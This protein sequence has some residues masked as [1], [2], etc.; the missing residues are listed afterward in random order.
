[1][2]TGLATLALAA[3]SAQGASNLTFD[4]DS[5]P[6][7]VL[8]LYADAVWY[9]DNGNPASGGYLSV[10]D[11]FNSQTGIIVFD[12]FDSGLIV[13]GFNFKVDLRIGNSSNAPEFRPAD[14]FSVNY[15]R[16]SDPVVQKVLNGDIP[17]SADFAAGLP[18]AGTVTGIAVG[19][20]TWSGNQLPDGADIEGIIVRVDNVTVHREPLPTRNGACDDPTS[21]QTGFANAD[22]PYDLSNLCWQ[23]LEIDLNEAGQLT[24][25]WKGTTLLDAFQ[26]TFLPSRGRIVFAGRTGGNNQNH[27][28]DNIVISTIAATTATVSGLTP[29]ITGFSLRIDDAPG[30]VVAADSIAVTLDGAAVSTVNTRVGET[31]TVAYALPAGQRF[32]SGAPHAVQISFRDGAGNEFTES[33][34]FNAP[35]YG[36]VAAAYRATDVNTAQTGFRIRPHQVAAANPNTLAWT[37]QQLAGQQGPN[38][39]D[40]AAYGITPDAQGFIAWQDPLDFRNASG[41]AGRFDYDFG[42][43]SLGIPGYTD[44]GSPLLSEDNSALEILTFVE[45]PTA[46]AYTMNVASDDGFRL[47]TGRD[48][49][50]VFATRLG[51]FD[52][53]RGVDDGTTFHVWI[54]EAGIYPMRLVWQ[55]GGGGAGLEWTSIHSDGSHSLVGDTSDARALKAYRTRTATPPYVSSILPARDATQAHAQPTVQVVLQNAG[56]IAAGSAQLSLNGAPLT[57]DSQTAAGQLTVSAVLPSLLASAS[58]NRLELTYTPTGATAVTEAWSFVVIAYNVLPTDG[59]GAP[60]SGTNPGFGVRTHQLDVPGDAVDPAAR[61]A[62]ELTWAEAVLAGRAGPNVADLTGF[63]GGVFHEATTINYAQPGDDGTPE[64]AG[65]FNPNRL[66]PGIPGNGSAPTDNI[67]SEILTFVELPAPGFYLMGVNSDDGF[68]VSAG[69]TAPA[70]PV[71][72]LAPAGIAGSIA[73]VPSVRGDNQGGGIFAPLP[74]TPIEADVVVGL[75]N[76]AT[77]IPEEGCGTALSNAAEVAGKI[78][79]VDRGTCTFLEKA[80]NAANAGAVGVLVAQNRS[81]YPIVLGGDPNTIAIPVLMISQADGARLRTAGARVRIAADP[82]VVLG[83]VNAGRGATDT[84]FGFQ[85]S[86]AG[87]YPLRLLWM[88]GGGGASVEWFSVAPDGTKILINDTASAQALRAFREATVVDVPTLGIGTADGN[89]V[90]TYS[91]TLQSAESVTG[92]YTA[93]PDAPANGPYT[94]APTG[95][96]RFYR[97]VR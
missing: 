61:M 62:T 70:L 41:G 93:V 46:G 89:V 75:G 73:A 39:V 27:H 88:E 1:M 21:L 28:L 82:A 96:L 26:T 53:G 40:L 63:T 49:R 90:I 8:N 45:F 10:T 80:R 14:G 84:L 15:A 33:R 58:T 37:E 72:A 11:N 55:N 52:G 22:D 18:E 6:S 87:L 91:G 44:D 29:S 4:F 13:K 68:R 50:D 35:A 64:T 74:L 31:T 69:H 12:D 94:V 48:A 79:L 67:V 57:T 71:Q 76:S 66:I 51:Q 77:A 92:P 25:K 24:V 36:L 65:N 81:D 7:G 5:D 9:G 43:D 20:D 59:A 95:T 30:S 3:L 2:R 54:E 42:F 83:S 47:Q 86:Q 85:A 97:A 60:G 17:A 34:T 38:L 23:P 16:E 32:D 78:V 56:S 19:F